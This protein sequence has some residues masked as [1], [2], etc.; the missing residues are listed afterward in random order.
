M[1]ASKKGRLLVFLVLAL[2][3]ISGLAEEGGD[4]LK[5]IQAQVEK[6]SQQL[7]R[8]QEQVAGLE[9]ELKTSEKEIRSLKEQEQNTGQALARVVEERD[10]L[11]TELQKLKREYAEIAH[12]SASRLRSLYMSRGNRSTR[13]DLV[14]LGESNV[15]KIA[16]YSKMVQEHDRVVLTKLSVAGDRIEKQTASLD[17]LV[18]DRD[19]L[20]A[21]LQSQR[22]KIVARVKTQRQVID[23]INKQREELNKALTR[24]RAQALRLE[25]VVASLT[26][27]RG[28]EFYRRQKTP[29]QKTT[30]IVAYEGKGLAAVKASLLLPIENSRVIKKFG[31]Q[32]KEGFAGFVFSKGIEFLTSPKVPVKVIAQGRVL[33]SGVMPG[34]GKILIV[35]HG[36]RSYSLYGQLATQEVRKGQLVR[37]GD[38]I[39]TAGRNP[40]DN[41][42]RLYFEIRKNGKPIDPAKLYGKRLA[43]K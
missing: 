37:R 30:T 38:M 40:Q 6:E 24:L 14:A 36:S 9:E 1:F 31:K 35:D 4:R 25:T 33:F 19:K 20:K 23:D 18:K 7:T 32:R 13:P 41:S 26:Q 2:A 10:Q 28:P 8:L 22:K 16:Y 5:E 11:A 43:L 29:E 12:L 39:A 3:P 17:D 34:Y 27:G 21:N 42:G 15:Q